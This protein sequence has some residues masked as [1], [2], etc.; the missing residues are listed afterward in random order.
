MTDATSIAVRLAAGVVAEDTAVE[1]AHELM[2]VRNDLALSQTHNRVQAAE[3][4]E[5]L[6]MLV[7]EKIDHHRVAIRAAKAEAALVALVARLDAGGTPADVLADLAT[8][9]DEAREIVPRT[10]DPN[11]SS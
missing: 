4:Q 9:L 7:G 1:L 5:H 11:C 3:Y 6:R 8:I 10:G 2:C